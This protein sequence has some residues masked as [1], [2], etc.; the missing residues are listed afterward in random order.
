MEDAFN[1]GTV[2]WGGIIVGLMIVTYTV[3]RWVQEDKGNWR[4]LLLPFLPLML[5]GMLLVLSAGGILG[6]TANFALWGS[7]HVGRVVLEGGVG[8]TDS[9][10]TRRTNVVLTSGGHTVVILAAT[11]FITYLAF[12]KNCRSN[13]KNQGWILKILGVFRYNV[14]LLLPVVAGISLGLA[15]GLAGLA[16]QGLAPAVDTLG[17]LF[18]EFAI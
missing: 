16:A 7:N 11:A 4:G 1:N 13:T 2:T 18:G 9:D 5:F 8:G 17:G 10:V 3:V 12:S 15:D 6:Q 14:S